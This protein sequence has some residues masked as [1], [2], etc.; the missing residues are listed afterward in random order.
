MNEQTTPQPVPAMLFGKQQDITAFASNDN[1][2]LSLTG[3]YYDD[4]ARSFIAMDGRC[5]IE[6]PAVQSYSYVHETPALPSSC[7]V[8][9]TAFKRALA[10]MSKLLTDGIHGLVNLRTV[11]THADSTRPEA[12]V[13]LTSFG[14]DET[15]SSTSNALDGAYPMHDWR[16]LWATERTPKAKVC[17]AAGVLKK[18]ADYACKAGNA[19]TPVD[20]TINEDDA[21]VTFI[22]KLAP[23]CEAKGMFMGLR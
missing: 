4:K 11:T 10:N 22:I 2:R 13:V 8:R 19:K 21:P 3:V 14:E 20:L 9:K 18:I 23:D 7:I 17:I 1:T 12:K 16:A 15:H 5:G 6:V